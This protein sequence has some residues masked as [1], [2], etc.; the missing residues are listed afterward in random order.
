M[1]RQPLPSRRS[2]EVFDL[3]F[4]EIDY[5]VTIGRYASGS[6][7]EVFISC[8]KAGSAVAN[9]A[10]DAAVVM[11][12]ALQHGAPL[13]ILADAVTRDEEGEAAGL[14]GA[15][16]DQIIRR[17]A[18]AP[19]APPPSSSGL[20]PSIAA[21]PASVQPIGFLGGIPRISGDICSTCGA[22]AM[23]RTGTCL[24]CQNCAST[25]GGCS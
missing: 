15:V 20:P 5:T 19:A 10:R 9:L 14:A 23:V 7:A 18:E 11:S 25:S 12:L 6:V 4:G 17:A 22:A 24:T 3:R 16:L 1:S 21:Q 13:Q 8:V 2:A